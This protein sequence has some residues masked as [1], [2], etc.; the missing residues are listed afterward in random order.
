MSVTLRTSQPLRS[1]LKASAPKNMELMSVTA[2]TSQ[3]AMVPLKATESA[4]MK[5][6]SVTA[7]TS[8]PAMGP[9]YWEMYSG[10]PAPNA[11]VTAS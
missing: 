10:P 9:W 6:M 7:L 11:S 1:P 5:L 2:L 4:N 8:Q 3:P